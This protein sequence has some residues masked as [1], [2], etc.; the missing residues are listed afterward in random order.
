MNWIAQFVVTRTR[1]AWSQA[2]LA[3][4]FIGAGTSWFAHLA[5]ENKRISQLQSSAERGSFEI[6]L[7][8]LN[9]NQ[10]GALGL[11]GLFDE[12]LKKE[13]RGELAPNSPSAALLM[14]NLARVHEADGAFI[15]GQDGIIKSSWGVGKPLTGVDVKFRPYAQM[16]L[17]GKENVYAA[18]GTTTGFRNLYFAAPLYTGNATDTEVIGAVVARTG[19][20]RLDRLL[21]DKADIALLL[22]PQGLVFASSREDWIGRLA[23]TATPDRIDAIRKVKQFGTMF[24]KKDPEALPTPVDP[25]SVT[26]EGRRHAVG[27]ATVQWNDPGGNWT[28][29]LMEDLSRTAPFANHIWVGLAS[30]LGILLFGVMILQILRGHHEQTVSAQQ[31]HEHARQ[32]ESI[33]QRKSGLAEASM[34]LQQATTMESLAQTLLNEANRMLGILQGAMYV[35]DNAAPDRLSLVAGYGCAANLPATVLLGEGLLGQCAREAKPIL[36]DT[37]QQGYWRISSGL[38]E[39]MPRMVAVLPI[40]RN[41][42][43]LGAV[44]LAAL[45]PLD[46]DDIGILEQLL[47][48]VALNLEI[49]QRN[50]Q[51]SEMASAT[52]AAERELARMA[53]LE[54]FNRLAH[55]R[56]QRILALKQEV[57]GLAQSVGRS[58]PYE[59]AQMASVESPPVRET[60]SLPEA[61]N[62]DQP[63][64]LGDLVDLN[65][66]QTLFANFCDAVGVAAAIIDL[67]GKILASSR[68]QRICTDFHRVNA[69]T[70]AR[71]IESDTQL[72]LQLQDGQDFTQYRC[73][74]GM[75][76]CASPIVVEGQHLANVFIGQFHVGPPDMEFFAGQAEKFGF[77]SADYLR[78]VSDAPVLDEGRLPAIL[79]FLTGFARMVASLSLQKRRADD[80]QQLLRRNAEILQQ[81]RIAALSL[82]E[83]AER[84]RS[85]LEAPHPEKIK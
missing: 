58:A 35:V 6:K 63:L 44:E 37:P 61:T 55:G 56:E 49:L 65:E 7:Q 3:S 28:L 43:L 77:P 83:D 52:V 72:A 19:V 51:A 5:D 46:S 32:Q 8:T 31:L 36:V 23:G 59:S 47:P 2:V 13:G 38:G 79:G 66:L 67:D 25:G 12:N 42:T 70:C 15:I 84:A 30:G 27:Q 81:E 85:T 17:K 73:K 54:R 26:L 40:L 71:C 14:K 39:T 11:L 75:T 22:S 4:L 41:E 82:A 57:N 1:L 68:W 76:D 64:T 21:A 62:D 74:N 80:A 60:V 53:E 78:A 69:D 10:M 20:A 29:V 18:I 24:D 34:R 16:A 50:H 9:G 45:R 33:A 48:Y